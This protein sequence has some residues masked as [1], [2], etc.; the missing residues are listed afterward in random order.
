MASVLPYEAQSATPNEEADT[1]ERA[2]A[3]D[4]AIAAQSGV[5]C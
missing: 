1:G 3:L 4:S 2:G 5:V